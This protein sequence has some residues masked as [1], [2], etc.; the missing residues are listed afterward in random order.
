MSSSSTPHD[1]LF[2]ATFTQPDL[3]RS[4][5]EL[6]LPG[7]VLAHLDLATLEVCAGSFV[8]DALRHAHTDLLYRA[9]IRGAAGGEALV[10]VLFEHHQPSTV[11]CRCGCSGTS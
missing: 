6:V 3:A 5:L 7:A 1:A 10:Y 2:K 8:D 9:S 4:E 11:D